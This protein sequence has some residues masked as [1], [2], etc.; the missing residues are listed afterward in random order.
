MRLGEVT[1][2]FPKVDQDQVE[3]FFYTV[4]FWPLHAGLSNRLAVSVDGGEP[5]VFENKFKEYDRTWK[6][7]VL[8]NG[9]PC[10]L[11]FAIDKT[12][13]SHTVTFRALD[14]GQMLQKAIIDW[15]GLQSSYLGPTN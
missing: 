13:S 5:Q 2:R 1:Y 4:P 11:Q 8:R 15:G 9:A 6:D 3:V 12:R 7:Q 10:R 14:D